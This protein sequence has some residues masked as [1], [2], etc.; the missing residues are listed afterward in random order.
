MALHGP[1]T[2]RDATAIVIGFVF[3]LE[4]IMLVEF[5]EDCSMLGASYAVVTPVLYTAP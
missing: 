3:G 5:I 4:T 2:G 1:L